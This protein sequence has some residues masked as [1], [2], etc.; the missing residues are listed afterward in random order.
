[1]DGD[2]P[3]LKKRRAAARTATRA[4]DRLVTHLPSSERASCPCSVYAEEA[5]AVHRLGPTLVEIVCSSVALAP[6]ASGIMYS[7]M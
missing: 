1:M 3:E 4:V 6:G 2:E 7:S 5:T